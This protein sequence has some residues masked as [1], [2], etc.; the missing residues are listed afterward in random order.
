MPQDEAGEGITTLANTPE[1][2]VY[3]RRL[4]TAAPDM[5]GDGLLGGA[6]KNGRNCMERAWDVGMGN[7]DIE[8]RNY[9]SS[10]DIM[11]PGGKARGNR[12]LTRCLM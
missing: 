3:Y 10:L 5:N 12:P 6:G 11:M 1:P 2:V 8:I 7:V 4:P 9:R